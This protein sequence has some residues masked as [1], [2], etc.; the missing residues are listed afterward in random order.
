MFAG[1]YM[2]HD[3]N[4]DGQI[5]SSQLYPYQLLNGRINGLSLSKYHLIK[6]LKEKKNDIASYNHLKNT[7]QIKQ[8]IKIFYFLRLAKRTYY[9]F[10]TL[11]KST[12]ALK[13]W[14]RQMIQ[15]EIYF[16]KKAIKLA[17]NKKQIRFIYLKY[18]HVIS[19]YAKIHTNYLK[20]ITKQYMKKTK[21]IKREWKNVMIHGLSQQINTNDNIMPFIFYLKKMLF[22][23][24][25]NGTFRNIKFWKKLIHSFCKKH[26]IMKEYDLTNLINPNNM[27][28]NKTTRENTV[29]HDGVKPYIILN[30]LS[31]LKQ[32]S[33]PFLSTKIKKEYYNF[34]LSMA[35]KRINKKT[36]NNPKRKNKKTQQYF[37]PGIIRKSKFFK[38]TKLFALVCGKKKYI[39]R[40]SYQNR[41]VLPYLSRLKQRE[42]IN[43]P[44]RKIRKAIENEF[45]L[46]KTISAWLIAFQKWKRF[47][48]F[49]HLRKLE[50]KKRENERKQ[51]QIFNQ[52]NKVN[53]FKKRR[54]QRKRKYFYKVRKALANLKKRNKKITYMA[55]LQKIL[56]N[57]IKNIKRKKTI[58]E[59]HN[60][61]LKRW[62]KKRKLVFH[63]KKFRKKKKGSFWFKKKKCRKRFINKMSRVS[64]KTA[65]VLTCQLYR[66]YT[67][68]WVETYK[69]KSIYNN[70]N[71]MKMTDQI[72]AKVISKKNKRFLRKNYRHM[73][74]SR[75]T[76]Y[77]KQ[78]EMLNYANSMFMPFK[79]KG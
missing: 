42:L 23:K 73:M 41:R 37:L 67:G 12:R 34:I 28:G 40:N 56:K 50:I 64:R 46:N 29:I 30:Y 27:L 35:K 68:N 72:L 48:I 74:N 25:R 16:L 10:S 65:Y 14:I 58:Y 76:I 22:G 49:K 17:K 26:K 36:K 77:I 78:Q 47:K 39:K 75:Y 7:K 3:Y 38:M 66:D 44:V 4:D 57:K 62:R 32:K 54:N 63:N 5:H 33:R 79:L 69:Q 52:L 53:R 31:K 18:K 71:D 6:K 59:L 21:R 1:R 45:M 2:E 55:R 13:V 61:T 60:R 43:V 51:S 19:K 20:Q 70:K 9:L 24:I 11:K 15:N 8:L